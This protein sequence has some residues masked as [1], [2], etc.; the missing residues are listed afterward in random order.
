MAVRLKCKHRGNCAKKNEVI[1]YVLVAYE[2]K[3]LMFISQLYLFLNCKTYGRHAKSVNKPKEGVPLQGRL[4]VHLNI[5]KEQGVHKSNL[6]L[7]GE[8]RHRPALHWTPVVENESDH[9]F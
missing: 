7:L 3:L 1:R 2:V 9:G 4:T 5:F 8:S 6:R